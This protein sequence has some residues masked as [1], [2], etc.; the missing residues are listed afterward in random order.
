MGASV[1]LI[2]PKSNDKKT[3]KRLFEIAN[4]CVKEKDIIKYPSF[5]KSVPNDNHISY[6]YRLPL[7]IPSKLIIQFQEVLS[8]GLNKPV[9]IDF[10]NYQLEIKVFHNELIKKYQWNKNVL[11][12]NSYEVFIGKSLT[13]DIFHDFDSSPHIVIGGGTGYGKTVLLKLIFTELILQNPDDVEFYIIDLK[14]ELEFFRYK[15]LK[16]VKEVA[17][18]PLEAFQL[19]TK[20]VADMF[21]TIEEL[22]TGGFETN[23]KNVSRKRKFVIVDE[24]AELAPHGEPKMKK[25]LYECQFMLSE[26]A[27]LGRA[28]GYRLIFATQYPT[29]DTLP[30]QIK[31]N[32]DCR[33]G[34]RLPTY[35]GS[36]VVIDEKGLEKLPY[37]LA[38]RAIMK[39]DKKTELQIP[40]IKDSTVWEVLKGYEEKKRKPNRGNTTK[41]ENT[42]IRNEKTV[43]RGSQPTRDK[44]RTEN[45]KNNGNGRIIIGDEVLK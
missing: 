45:T 41:Y 3:I 28:V 40:N 38:G 32:A 7:G 29:S 17:G 10:S 8:E 31:Q 22:K 4:M 34:L 25:L 18:N 43:T 26:I 12:P 30:R 35:T 36:E 21:T 11:K 44:K 9:V 39:T 23:I 20:L 2:K 15:N 13:E 33:I 6:F 16:Q 19:L 24:A 5:K 42:E 37:K 1:G 14:E 27:R